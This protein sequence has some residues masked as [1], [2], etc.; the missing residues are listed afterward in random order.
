MASEDTGDETPRRLKLRPPL[1]MGIVIVLL[2]ALAFFGE[3][4][5]M[6]TFRM[7]EYRAELQQR[8]DQLEAD[9]RELRQE[10]ERLRNDYFYLEGLARKNLGMVKEDEL[11][12]QFPRTPDPASAKASDKDPAD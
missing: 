11:V 7:L 2:F 6:R 8:I 12:Y 10:V 5:I 1:W 9:N 4:G 3:R